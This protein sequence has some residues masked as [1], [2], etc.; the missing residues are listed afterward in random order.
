M[1]TPIV[2]TMTPGNKTVCKGDNVKFVAAAAQGSENYAYSWNPA[3]YIS[4]PTGSVQVGEAFG[5]TVYNISAYDIA[6]PNYVIQTSFTLTVDQPPVPNMS[7]AK[8]NVCEP[9]C[10]IF[11]THTNGKSAQVTYD[12]GNNHVVEGDS[13]NVCLMAGQHYMRI[14][15]LGTN[16]CKGIYDYTVPI[17]VYPK[18][19]TDFGWTPETPNTSN[20]L[21]TFV[22]TTKHGKTFTYE[23]Q[24][25]N[26]TNVGGIDTSSIKNPSKIYDNN[27]KFPAMLVVRNEYGCTD[28]VFKIVEIEEDVNVFIPNTF[29]P[30][31]DNVNDVFNVKGLGL[32]QTG[33]YMEVFDRW[34]TL[35]Y[36]T[37]DINKGWDGTV[38]GVKAAEGVYI[39][40]IKVV[41]TNGVGKKDFKG[42]VTLMK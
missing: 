18:P 25:T 31:D 21:V 32:Q 9:L 23:W 38:K 11:N 13:V 8:N 39:Y 17:T 35:V 10:M 12:F 7:L 20:N 22:P 28:S 14:A 1:L 41:G 36:S 42:H 15:T 30:N 24:F 27:G 26:S 2:F 29:T 33:F 16:G 3:I 6:C 4:S 40:Q 34:G 5:T 37:K 19:G